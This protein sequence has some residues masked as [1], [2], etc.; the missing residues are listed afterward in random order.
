MIEIEKLIIE[1]STNKKALLEYFSVTDINNIDTV[2]CLTMLR[3]KRLKQKKELE[4][5]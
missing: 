4:D 1:T 5:E 2:K 3:A